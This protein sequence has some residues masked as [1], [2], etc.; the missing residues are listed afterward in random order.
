MATVWP[1]PQSPGQIE[2]KILVV[3]TKRIKS[4]SKELCKNE[5]DAGFMLNQR[6]GAVGGQAFVPCGQV[7]ISA[8]PTLF[9]VGA[10][11]AR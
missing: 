5:C 3:A 9:C 4:D 7:W 11:A 6:H 10:V 1:S 2:K 8:L